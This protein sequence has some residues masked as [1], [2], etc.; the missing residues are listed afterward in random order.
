MAKR[1]DVSIIIPAYNE[2]KYI[3][4]AL[5]SLRRQKSSLTYEIIVGD[6]NCTDNTAKIAKDYGA[7]VVNESYN[8]PSGGRHAAAK[9]AK[10]RLFFF[11][12]AD[13]ELCPGWLEGMAAAFKDRKVTWAIG[14]IKPFNGN[15]L[16]DF[17][18]LILNGLAYLLNPLGI[19]YVNADNLAARSDAY[20]K[21]GGF[22][23]K[24]VTAEDTDLGKRL[25]KGGKFAFA[26]KA[27]VLL[28]M[29]RVRKWGYFRFIVFHTSNFF[30]ANL[31]S[32][33]SDRYDP[34]R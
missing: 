31:F 18:A 26:K 5:S 32:S 9:A 10:G 23:P 30:A 34:V 1:P 28:S 33:S 27:C 24:I 12:S 13:V 11:V 29:R 20:F 3:G 22:N 6:G 17:G 14:R 7:K 15:A 21:A 16:E 8:T 2:E 4:A 19:A 25:M